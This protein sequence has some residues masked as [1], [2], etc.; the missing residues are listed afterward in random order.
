MHSRRMGDTY[1]PIKRREGGR[2]S[3]DGLG[4]CFDGTERY[5]C[6]YNKSM[7][8]LSVERKNQ[9]TPD[10][11]KQVKKRYMLRRRADVIPYSEVF[12]TNIHGS[13]GQSLARNGDNCGYI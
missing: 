9:D 11:C 4:F 2:R 1:I 6:M 8:V 10:Y 3:V 7:I 13:G 5:L 12:D